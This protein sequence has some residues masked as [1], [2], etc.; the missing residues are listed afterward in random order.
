MVH[1]GMVIGEIAM[2]NRNTPVGSFHSGLHPADQTSVFTDDNKIASRDRAGLD[3]APLSTASL[4]PSEQNDAGFN[5][6]HSDDQTSG[7]APKSVAAEYDID[8]T[9]AEIRE[10]VRAIVSKI[11][12]E[13]MACPVSDETKADFASLDMIMKYGSLPTLRRLYYYMSSAGRILTGVV[14]FTLVLLVT[15]SPSRSPLPSEM[16]NF[17]EIINQHLA[18]IGLL[19]GLFL[20]L[21]DQIFQRIEYKFNQYHNKYLGNIR[22]YTSNMVDNITTAVTDVEKKLEAAKNPIEPTASDTAHA[23]K[24]KTGIR[25]TMKH[26]RTLERL[27]FYLR[28]EWNDYFNEVMDERQIQG[29]RRK[30][31]LPRAGDFAL[32]G[33]LAGGGSLAAILCVLAPGMLQANFVIAAQLIIASSIVLMMFSFARKR[34][35]RTVGRLTMWV[36]YALVLTLGI[37]SVSFVGLQVLAPSTLVN[38]QNIY[39]GFGA[40]F[41]VTSLAG[42]LF[43]NKA[44]RAYKKL[45]DVAII[46]IICALR[47]HKKRTVFETLKGTEAVTIE[48]VADINEM[49]AFDQFG[50]TSVAQR[51]E[52]WDGWTYEERND[53]ARVSGTTDDNTPDFLSDEEHRKRIIEDAKDEKRYVGNEKNLRMRVTQSDPTPKFLAVIPYEGLRSN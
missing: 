38:L 22:Q 11:K 4:G 35:D 39:L 5:R 48:S 9:R 46:L 47:T 12:K 34:K 10:S 19:G 27:P 50:K 3:T 7:D 30:R 15:L 2:G 37:F 25:D 26:W 16:T 23:E 41:G 51:D 32:F 1:E 36:Q 33:F 28:N 40:Y 43:S 31:I 45:A 14:F 53:E 44:G 13:W 18:W 49:R 20:P 42:L 29:N 17:V 21:S 24:V 8:A 52:S 6:L